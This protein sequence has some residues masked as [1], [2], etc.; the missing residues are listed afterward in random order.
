[1]A[2]SVFFVKYYPADYFDA[3]RLGVR[4]LN[5]L[6]KYEKLIKADYYRTTASWKNH[7]PVFQSKV[8]YLGGN[9]RLFVYTDDR[10]YGEID[11]GTPVRYVTMTPD[12]EPKT[13]ARVLDSFPGKGKVAYKNKN[14]PRPGIEPRWFSD[15]ITV[16]Y[17]DRITRDLDRATDEGLEARVKG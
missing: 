11:G 3:R 7:H 16:K 12:F 8:R 6:R 17:E 9:P 15:E 14:I 1:M 10:V 13:R 4:W 2:T 5:V